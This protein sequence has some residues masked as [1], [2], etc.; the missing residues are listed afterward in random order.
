[1]ERIRSLVFAAGGRLAPSIEAQ[2]V[3]VAVMP[4]DVVGRYTLKQYDDQY[5]YAVSRII[6]NTCGWCAH[7]KLWYS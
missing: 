1:M 4:A 2:G 3:Q 6:I 5:W 7:N